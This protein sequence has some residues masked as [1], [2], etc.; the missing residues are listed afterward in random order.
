MC[1][2]YKVLNS[3]NLGFNVDFTGQILKLI[4]KNIH[5]IE[6][7]Y[8]LKQPKFD[9]NGKPCFG[10]VCISKENLEL[11][12]P[13]L[14]KSFGLASGYFSIHPDNHTINPE[15]YN[16]LIEL[17]HNPAIICDKDG[18]YN[19]GCDKCYWYC[20]NNCIG[21]GNIPNCSECK[22]PIQLEFDFYLTSTQKSV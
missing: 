6:D 12:I 11:I 5:N 21:S 1:E 22:G 18:S 14:K 20:C 15:C 10:T 16:K 3:P 17:G 2:F 4:T 7:Y 8:C 13:K 9:N 19:I